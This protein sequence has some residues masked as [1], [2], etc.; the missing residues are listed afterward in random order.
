M[1]EASKRGAIVSFAI[2]AAAAIAIAAGLPELSFAPGRPLP[3]RDGDSIE[4]VL[5]DS[6]SG[7]ALPIDKFVAAAALAMAVIACAAAIVRSIAATSVKGT[8]RFLLKA[9]GLGAAVTLILFALLVSF[10]RV[11]GKTTV[12][13]DAS[14]ARTIYAEGPEQEDPPVVLYWILAAAVAAAGAALLAGLARSSGA[15]RARGLDGIARE[16]E[17]ARLG[18]LSGGELGDAI[19]ACYRRMGRIVKKE[20]GIERADSMT[21]REFEEAMIGTG[22]DEEGVRALTR[23]FESARYGM[24]RPSG[25]DERA[26][27]RCLESIA[28][29]AREGRRK[30]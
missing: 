20:R 28:K 30:P 27:I 1:D 12:Q 9:L 2:A 15:K 8:G 14:P 18:I 16:A 6:E 21:A 23:L 22:I 10:P 13:A 4:I 17:D 24:G 7:V 26:A 3:E 19:V 29:S 25:E 11:L 5:P